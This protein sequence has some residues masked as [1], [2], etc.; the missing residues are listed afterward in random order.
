MPEMFTPV[1]DCRESAEDEIDEAQR[2]KHG[3]KRQSR[4][5]A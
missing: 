4:K 1:V 2:N 5:V 3:D